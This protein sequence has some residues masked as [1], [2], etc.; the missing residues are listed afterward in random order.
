MKHEQHPS[1]QCQDALTPIKKYK[2]EALLVTVPF[3]GKIEARE[4]KKLVKSRAIKQL[5]RAMKDCNWDVQPEKMI[6]FEE[7]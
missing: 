7:R 4:R 5:A 6:A 3:Y 1:N 2:E